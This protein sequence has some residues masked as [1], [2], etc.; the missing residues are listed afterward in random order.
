MIKHGKILVATDFSEQS[1]EALRRGMELAHAFEA[2]IYLLHV[3]EP[4]MLYDSDRHAG[5]GFIRGA[6]Y[7]G[8]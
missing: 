5:R 7:G 1:D 6:T 3:M 8:A 2:E 4:F